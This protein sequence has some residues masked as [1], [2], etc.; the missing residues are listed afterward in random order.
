MQGIE[1]KMAAEWEEKFDIEVEF[2]KFLGEL[3]D[4][5]ETIYYLRT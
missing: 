2:P 4:R 5:T 3:V 1:Q